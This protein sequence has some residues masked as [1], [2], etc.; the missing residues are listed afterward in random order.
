M[1]RNG[2]VQRENPIRDDPEIKSTNSAFGAPFVAVETNT[3][4]LPRV[5]SSVFPLRTEL[6]KL[7]LELIYS[8]KVT[9]ELLEVE[10]LLVISLYGNGNDNNKSR[11]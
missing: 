9:G 8:T 7:H 5:E 10:S 1:W 2:D 3:C 11:N 4:K 6:L